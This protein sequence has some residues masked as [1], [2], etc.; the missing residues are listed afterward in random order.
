M[1]GSRQGHNYFSDVATVPQLPLAGHKALFTQTDGVFVVDSAGKIVRLDDYDLIHSISGALSAEISGQAVALMQG[2]VGVN[3]GQVSASI[4]HTEIS[5]TAAYPIVSLKGPDATSVI[6]PLSITNRST[7]G[8]DVVLGGAP[9]TVGYSIDWFMAAGGASVPG[10]GG[11]GGAGTVTIS[12][13]TT[14]ITNTSTLQFPGASISDAGGGTTV[15]SISGGGGSSTPIV[16]TGSG[17]TFSPNGAA[18]VYDY[19][20]TAS[21][22]VTLN[23][24]T[25]FTN[26]KSIVFKFK[27][28]AGGNAPISFANGSGFT[29]KLPNGTLTLSTDTGNAEDIITVIRVGTNL[30]ASIVKNF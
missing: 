14:T 22:A 21:S 3:S 23:A 11:G 28:P 10:P 8:F 15:I 16:T 17:N 19:T 24:P 26:G 6:Y 4:A 5:L 1:A 29:W 18:D 25:S 9:D 2:N 27:Q 30:Y 12:D 20:I 13:G 7:T